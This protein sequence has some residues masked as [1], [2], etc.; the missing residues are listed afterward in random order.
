MKSAA[1]KL[2]LNIYILFNGIL[3]LNT[4]WSPIESCSRSILDDMT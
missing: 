1:G 4:A 2:I 3:T